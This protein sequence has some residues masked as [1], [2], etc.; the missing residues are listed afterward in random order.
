L[1]FG[2][3]R[4]GIDV[5]LRPV[6]ATRVSGRLDGASAVAGQMLRMMPA[7]AEHLGFG[8]EIATTI[9]E[10]D[11]TFTFLNVPEGQYTI[12][13]QPSLLD[14]SIDSD[15]DARLANPPGFASSSIAVGSVRA[16]PGLS[17]LAS[18]SA[19]VDAVW[20]RVHVA[21]AGAEVRNVVLPLHATSRVSGHLVFEGNSKRPSSPVWLQFSP[22]VADITLGEHSAFTTRGDETF[23]F[24]CDSFLGGR[25]LLQRAFGSWGVISITW[26]GR[27][28]THAGFDMS[29][30]QNYDDV[31]V[32]ATD[33]LIQFNGTVHDALGR[34]AAAAVL[35]FPADRGRWTDYGWSPTFFDSRRTNTNGAFKAMA[36]ISA[37]DYFVIAVPVSQADAWLDP[38]FL[39]AAAPRATRISLAWGETKTEELQIIEGIV[40]R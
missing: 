12:L 6:P 2:E 13:L 35:I 16:A 23:A 24:A 10:S 31:I 22:A 30:G 39:E 32:T 18:R 14:V 8:S 26:N 15:G 36:P 40:A 11:R 19:G 9:V 20:G 28:L 21:V 1:A 7:G 17:Y 5:Q 37:G 33:K 29:N 4:T 25:Y 27:D 34:P 38:R 3:E